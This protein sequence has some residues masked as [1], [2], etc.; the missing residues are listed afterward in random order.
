M[1]TGLGHIIISLAILI[2]IIYYTDG[3]FNKKVAAIFLIN[4][5]IGPDSAQAYGF[6][7]DL[8]GIDF[9]WFI[10]FL[11]WAI[12]LALFFSYFSRFSI[13]RTKHFFEIV[14]DGRRE[15][16]WKNSYLLCVSGGLLHTIADA[17]FRHDTHDSTIKLLDNVL[18]PHLGDLY[19]I[20]SYGVEVGA[21]QILPFIIMFIV[22][23]LAV[24][25]VEQEYKDVLIIYAIISGLTLLLAFTFG[26]KIIGEEYGVAVV[27]LA[28][29]FILLPI[30]LL[31]HVEKDVK[32]NPTSAPESARIDAKL[33][34]KLVGITSIVVSVVFLALGI[35][36]FMSSPTENF[37]DLN[38]GLFVLLG[39]VI[40]IV[41][42]LM[43]VGAIGLFLKINACRNIM[44]FACAV[45]TIFI[46]PLVIFYYLCQ[47]DIKALFKKELDE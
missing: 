38:E 29:V 5:W 37:L 28:T 24:Y 13:K 9:H 26:D 6:L 7:E 23:L 39:F 34:I 33:G 20:A 31:F 19:H 4:N 10:P 30:I 18:Q 25:I 27:I 2:P 3:E 15:L 14:D 42:G 32:K 12:P 47:N 1:P 46:Y 16:N 35:L 17:I 11:I 45:T 41:G 43:M 21:L 8:T 44:M 40:L 36:I 22:V